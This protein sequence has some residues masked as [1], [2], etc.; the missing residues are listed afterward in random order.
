[1]R[2]LSPAAANL[3]AVFAAFGLTVASASPVAAQA[4]DDPFA[5]PRDVTIAAARSADGPGL[6]P[7]TVDGSERPRMVRLKWVG[8]DIAIDADAA[9]AAGLPVPV[10]AKGWILLKSLA[11]ASWN[12]DQLG[13]MLAVKLFRKGDGPNDIDFAREQRAA[14][15]RS[16]LPALLI[17][18][19]LTATLSGRSSGAGAMIA[20]RFVYGNF[21]LRGAVQ[22]NTDTQPGASPFV[23][24]ETAAQMAVR[25]GTTS[26]TVGDFI[27]AGSTSQRALRL[28]GLQFASDFAL[29]PDLVTS[30]LPVFAGNVAVPT[31]IDLIVNDQRLTRQDVEAGEFRLRNIPISPGRGEFSVVVQDALGRETV[32]T[33]QVYVSQDM[34]AAGL[35]QY[36]ANMGWVRRRYGVASNDYRDMAATFFV[37]RGLTRGLSVGVSGETGLGVWNLGAEAQATLGGFAMGFAELRAS[38][39]GR[40]NGHL[41][42]AGVESLGRGL[43]GR[44]EMVLPSRGYRDIAAQSGDPLQERQ[45]NAAISFDLRQTLKLQVTGSRRWRLFDPRY[46]GQEPRIDVARATLRARLRDDIDAY[47]DLSYRNG[48]GT[49]NVA[50]MVGISM[51]LGAKRTAQGTVTRRNSRMQAQATLSRPDVV[52]GDV[53]YR[54][55][56]AT[57]E[58]TRVAGALAWRSRF[59]RLQGEAEYDRGH[60]AIRG[61]ARGTLIVAGGRLFARAQSGAAYALVTT[62]RV[63]GVTVTREHALAGKTDSS[64]HLLVENVTPL[65]PIQFD[66][67]ADSLPVEAVA[68]ATRRR[69]IA[70]RGGVV[71]VALDVTAFRSLPLRITGPT[72]Q[73]LPLGLMLTGRQ[74]GQS[75]MIG[76]DGLIDFNA[77]SGDRDLAPADGRWG[78][79]TLQ[80]PADVARRQ[81]Q[82]DLRTSCAAQLVAT[83][84]N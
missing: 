27:S 29:R 57:G 76:Y 43:S 19:D 59:T 52:A 46:P 84:E 15:Q 34:L 37:R 40:E 38:G 30:P 24:L 55:E 77:L 25:S 73:P 51:R 58:G 12:F 64:G 54:V 53:G 1:M 9:V 2:R 5:L 74:T 83:A 50:A 63:P 47:A 7:I 10:G 31:G 36:G 39:N 17:D 81:D 22:A 11:V 16:D 14:G 75:Y 82:L 61:N 49:R 35:W 8:S 3:A 32:K 13:Q 20:P 6:T 23:R 18:Y 71:R 41:L 33:A 45:V 68:H 26:V 65:V 60:G 66:V 80:I 44:V 56:A 42:R 79:C 67:D 28:G 48:G 70:A 78:G 72:G 62:G 4:Q 69:I 21:Q